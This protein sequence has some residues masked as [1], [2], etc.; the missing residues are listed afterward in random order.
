MFKG[1]PQ[2]E[3]TRPV[4]VKVQGTEHLQTSTFRAQPESFRPFFSS[5]VAALRYI[6]IVNKQNILESSFAH[7]VVIKKVKNTAAIYNFFFLKAFCV[8]RSEN[9]FF[10]NFSNVNNSEL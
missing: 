10:S 6:K 7:D 2:P 5:R 8:D 3:R 1:E 4:P 9:F